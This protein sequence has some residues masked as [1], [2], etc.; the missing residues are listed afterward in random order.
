MISKLKTVY[1][2][3]CIFIF[4]SCNY[5]RYGNGIIEDTHKTFERNKGYIYRLTFE[6]QITKKAICNEC[7]LN[8]YTLTLKLNQLSEKPVIS[9]VEFPPY[10]TFESD[11]IL[12][13]TVSKELFVKVKER[14]KVYK[15]KESFNLK[16]ENNELLYLNKEQYKW[17][18]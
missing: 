5:N 3:L 7:E 17:L 12:N 14:D 10:Y 13:I 16:A 15:E 8:K 11:S 1:M 9:N 18:P 6:G 2:M 4:S